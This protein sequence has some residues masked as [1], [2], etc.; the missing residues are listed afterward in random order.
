[1]PHEKGQQH[2][3]LEMLYNK[4]HKHGQ[5]VIENAFYKRTQNSSSFSPDFLIL[6]MSCKE[7]M[8]KIKLDVTLDV[9]TC[10]YLLHNLTFGK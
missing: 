3:I 4:K 5:Y 10:C 6:T 8:G 2:S 7:L 1:M 9:F